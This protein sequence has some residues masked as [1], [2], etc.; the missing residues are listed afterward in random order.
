MLPLQDP[1]AAARELRRAVTELGFVRRL[2]PAQPL[3]RPLAVG[4]RLRRRVGRGRGARRAD[5]HPRGQFGHR[6]DAR[7][8]PPL[9]P[10]GPARRV[11]LVRGDAGLRPAHRVR[12]ARAAPRP[13][14]H[15]PRVVRRLGPVLAGAAGR[16]GGVLRR[17]LPRHDAAALG[18]LR[19]PVRHQL[20]G[21]RAHPARAGALRRR[22]AH[23]L[24]QR[25]PPPRRHLPRRRRRHPGHRR[26]LPHRDPGAACSGSTPAGSTA[27]R[28][29]HSGLPGL[30]DDYFAAVTAQDIDALRALFAPDAVLRERG[31]APRG[32][33]RHLRLL[34]R[35]HLHLRGLPPRPRPAAASRARG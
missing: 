27:S 8:G 19:P 17:L 34:H 25:L 35:Q 12:R 32:P 21:R 13:A 23:R 15:L 6:A 2:R 3:P 30:I 24:G 14:R 7:L 20:R 9:Q 11:A 18:V 10:A 5:R 26:P 29:R 28:P 22:A 4:P 1:A 33:R 16:A 31:R